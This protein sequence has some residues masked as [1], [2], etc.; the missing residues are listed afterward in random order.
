M[1]DNLITVRPGMIPARPVRPLTDAEKARLAAMVSTESLMAFAAAKSTST[2]PQKVKNVKAPVVN[3]YLAER[4]VPDVDS[5]VWSKP[6]Y[7]TKK[8]LSAKQAR[9]ASK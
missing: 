9:S 5:L 8:R 2:R 4:S 1:N 3:T 6:S 7:G